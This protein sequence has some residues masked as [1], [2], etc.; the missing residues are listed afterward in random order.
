[1]PRQFAFFLPQFHS[2]PENDLWWGKGFT[3]WV[4]VKKALPL[5]KGHIQPKL[6]LNANYYNLLDKRIVLWQTKLM[7]QYHID[8]LIYYHYYFKGNLLLEKPA[9]NLLNWKDINQPF[10]FCWANHSWYKSWKGTK[11]LLLEIEYGNEKDWERHFQYLLPFFKDNRYEKR[12]NKPVFMV[13]KND[14]PEKNCM[15]SYFDKRCKDYGFEGICI[16]ET[17]LHNYI[18]ATINN[19]WK[20]VS[21]QTDFIFIREPDFS[22]SLYITDIKYKFERIKRWLDK[23]FSKLIG[24]KKPPI[25]NGEKLYSYMINTAFIDTRF[26][27]G[28]FFEWDNTP[29]HSS[30]GYVITP[31]TKDLYFQYMDKMKNEEYIFI[32]AWNEWAEGMMLEPTESDGFKYL[33]WINEWSLRN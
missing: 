16:I 4:N 30:R 27:H 28:V 13:F 5:Y 22:R 6:P 32:N 29:R 15:F 20:N 12:N 3:E 31:V 14:F 19:F 11:E 2:I 24:S 1:M 9:E 23:I 8:G 10:F 33:E 26:I 21:K 18:K 7:K 17:V 25:F